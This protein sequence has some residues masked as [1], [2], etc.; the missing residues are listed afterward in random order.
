MLRPFFLLLFFQGSFLLSGQEQWS[1][2]SCIEHAYNNNVTLQQSKILVDQAAINLK[3]S[4]HKR[5]PDLNGSLNGGISYGRNVDPT[6]N[7]FTTEDI[8]YSNYSLSSSVVLFQGGLI[9]N[10]IKQ[11]KLNLES[12]TKDYEQAKNDLA[13]TIAT[14]YLNVL[15]NQEKLGIAVKNTEIAKQQLDQINKL[16]KA[17][18]K[19]EAD[20]LELQSQLARADQSFV[21]A[22][23]ALDL[24]WLYLKQAL[25]LDPETK[26]SL[27]TLSEEQLNALQLQKYT[28]A[29]LLSNALEN[30]PGMQAAKIRL[31]SAIVGEK[32]ARAL[33]YP[34]VHFSASIGSRYSDAAF[35]YRE[36]LVRTELPG[37]V[38]ENNPVK[39]EYLTPQY[40][41]TG[42][43]PFGTQFD[44]FL[45]YG[46]GVSVNIPIFTN[47]STRGNAQKAKLYTK[48][49]ELDLELQKEKLSQ[50]IY[51]AMANVKSAIKE[52]EA[53]QK[54]FNA[55]KSSFEKTQI[56][57]D[58][59]M[60]NVFEL[61]QI[62]TN[63]LN[64]ETSLL[65]SKYDLVFKQKVLDYYAGKII[66]L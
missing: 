41:Q 34:S 28:F 52:Y 25:R 58:I 53:S 26:M 45:G 50:D 1:L 64:A 37:V 38:I 32:I 18:A 11:S 66:R 29:E 35:T 59:G 3:E 49:S 56:R 16:I 30:Q 55:A 22:E 39:V 60:A 46:G 8:L 57:F 24:A 44:Q 62:Q 21:I 10:S 33:Y 40:V 54:V 13:L 23:N 2:M 31:E 7:E 43:I 20:A 9:H 6:T 5:F 19:P 63:Y 14:Y 4:R 48:S 12:A 15:Q 51:Q 61:N 42:I 27:E 47:Y 36:E 65:I 17:G